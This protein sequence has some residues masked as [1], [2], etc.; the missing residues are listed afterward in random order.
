MYF[1]IEPY[2]AFVSLAN[3]LNSHYWFSFFKMNVKQL[4]VH[5]KLHETLFSRRLPQLHS[6][7]TSIGISAEQYL[8]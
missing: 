8:V 5:L 2:E 1:S 6:H 7:F 3:L 4:L